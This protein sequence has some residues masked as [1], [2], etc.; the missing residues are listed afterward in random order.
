MKKKGQCFLTK[1]FQLTNG[2]ETKNIE[3]CYQN[4]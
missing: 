3:N 2:E 4:E 1:E